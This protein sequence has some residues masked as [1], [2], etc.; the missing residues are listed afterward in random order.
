MNHQHANLLHRL[1]QSR[2]PLAHE[3]A[4]AIRQLTGEPRGPQVRLDNAAAKDMRFLPP[5][6][7]SPDGRKKR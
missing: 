4:E 6:T 3:A 1:E 7:E 2:E 5:G